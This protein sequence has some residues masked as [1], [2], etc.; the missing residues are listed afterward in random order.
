MHPTYPGVGGAGRGG[1]GPGTYIQY[2][3]YIRH[4]AARHARAC[5][6]QCPTAEQSDCLVLRGPQPRGRF[7]PAGPHVPANPFLEFVCIIFSEPP[8]DPPQ[9]P[10]GALER[11]KWAP[12][13]SKKLHF[14]TL[15]RA[16]HHFHKIDFWGQ[17]ASK[18][19]KVSPR[20][21]TAS[22][23]ESKRD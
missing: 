11:K 1:R 12:R 18:M 5:S 15:A 22:I 6:S 17:K 8:R 10:S 14:L 19:T 2:L 4:R 23:L 7:Y 20:G 16:W 13:V 3:L 21:V 9:E